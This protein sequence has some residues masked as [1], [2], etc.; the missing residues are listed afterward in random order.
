MDTAAQAQW[1]C[2]LDVYIKQ[3]AIAEKP[4]TPISLSKVI[5]KPRVRS[6][7]SFYLHFGKAKEVS[8]T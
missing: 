3:K 6:G 7:L 5:K 4:Q 8:I 2:W 1:V